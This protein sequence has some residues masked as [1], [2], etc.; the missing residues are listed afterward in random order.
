MGVSGRAMLEQLLQGKTDPALLA[1]LAKGRLRE[2]RELLEK[3]L[4]AVQGHHRFMLVQHLSHI[5]FLD[6]QIAKL[7][8]ELN[9]Q[10][11]LF[12]PS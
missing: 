2:K 3:A 1:E 4:T 10:M 11:R 8:A 7:D 6:E 9:D 5:D 12:R